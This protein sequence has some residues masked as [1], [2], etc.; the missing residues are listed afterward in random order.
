MLTIMTLA[1][2]PL[3]MQ[4]SEIVVVMGLQA[5]RS[6]T[7][8]ITACRACD[9][10]MRYGVVENESSVSFEITCSMRMGCDLMKLT[11]DILETS[12]SEQEPPDLSCHYSDLATTHPPTRNWTRSSSVASNSG[13]RT[14]NA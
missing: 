12:A 10:T 2:E 6:V 3:D 8:A 13:Y 4:R 14:R 1:A 9:D 5:R 11:L 7:A